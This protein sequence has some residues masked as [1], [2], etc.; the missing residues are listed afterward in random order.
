MPDVFQSP[1]VPRAPLPG[2]PESQAALGGFPL[3]F[4]HLQSRSTG[5]TLLPGGLTAARRAGGPELF[6][7]DQ[8]GCDSGR[9]RAVPSWV[10]KV[11]DRDKNE[12]VAVSCGGTFLL[13]SSTTATCLF[14]RLESLA[15]SQQGF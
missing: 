2:G 15:W 12:Q 1:G 4:P 14:T 7:P 9:M 13:K 6:C 3:A 5:T 8:L 11:H 10:D